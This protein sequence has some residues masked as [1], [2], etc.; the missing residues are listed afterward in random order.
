M[1]NWS[2]KRGADLTREMLNDFQAYLTP[3]GYE[4]IINRVKEETPIFGAVTCIASLTNP[5]TGNIIQKQYF[6]GGD[7]SC[8][9]FE[10][11]A[12]MCGVDSL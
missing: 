4:M 11:N 3:T 1:S 2:Y 12:C 5:E 7:E 6:L 10:L 9:P 8:A